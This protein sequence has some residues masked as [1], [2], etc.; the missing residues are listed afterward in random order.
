MLM[1]YDCTDI[2]RAKG[3]IERE[4][5]W[6]EGGGAKR[7]RFLALKIPSFFSSEPET[8]VAKEAT[9]SKRCVSYTADSWNPRRMAT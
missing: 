6:A 8:D 7:M 2:L 9:R 1:Y 5:V 4:R 3:V